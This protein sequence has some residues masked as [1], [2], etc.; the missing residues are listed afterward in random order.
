MLISRTTGDKGHAY[1]IHPRLVSTIPST[2]DVR[3]VNVTLYQVPS[4][5][6]TLVTQHSVLL[7]S[8]TTGVDCYK[9]HA[10][11]IPWFSIHCYQQE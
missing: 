7:I 6:P 2:A 1:G 9:G 8:R 10:Y 5:H 4:I 11:G 3:C